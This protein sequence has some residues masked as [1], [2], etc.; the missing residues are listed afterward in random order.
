VD[1]QSTTKGFL[2]TLEKNGGITPD[3]ARCVLA[4]YR[5]MRVISENGHEVDT[6]GQA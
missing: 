2:A 3:E 6:P 5:K 1:P 4:L